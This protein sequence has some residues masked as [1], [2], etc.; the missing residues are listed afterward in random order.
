M[1]AYKLLF[2]V[3]VVSL[4]TGCRSVRR[5]EPITGT[6]ERNDAVTQQGRAVFQQHCFQCHPGG[7]GGLG[8]GLNDKFAPV[9][10]MKT[11]VRLGL[12]V[13]PSFGEDQI[14]SA[15]LDKLMKYVIALR[16]DK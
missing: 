13:M 9:W 1:R 16:K 14:S 12:G 2:M 3:A 15:D 6:L 8:P 5:G 7:E 4:S 11:Q 10:L